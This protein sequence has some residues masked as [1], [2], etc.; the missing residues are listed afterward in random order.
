MESKKPNA[1]K[2]K[3]ADLIKELKQARREIKRLSESLK[4]ATKE[5]SKRNNAKDEMQAIEKKALRSAA[6]HFEEWESEGR[7]SH[8]MKSKTWD[9]IESEPKP[10]PKHWGEQFFEAVYYSN[11]EYY[12]Q[13]IAEGIKEKKG[14][15]A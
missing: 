2:M 12:M 8:G 1:E 9:K 15:D 5:I 10:S 7:P 14:A 6:K 4:E 13:E 3:K 11:L